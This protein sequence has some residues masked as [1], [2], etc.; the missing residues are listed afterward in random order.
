MIRARI[1][2]YSG[3]DKEVITELGIDSFLNE[4][5]RQKARRQLTVAF[6]ELWDEGVTVEFSDEVIQVAF[7]GGGW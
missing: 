5:D 7:G 3:G 4:K 2:T 1:K 6:M